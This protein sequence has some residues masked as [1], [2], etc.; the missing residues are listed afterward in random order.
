MIF[1]IKQFLIKLI[2][3]IL[4]EILLKFWGLKNLTKLFKLTKLQ[5]EE[6]R[7]AILQLILVFS[8]RLEN[9]LLPH[10]RQ[11]KRALIWANLV[12]MCQAEDV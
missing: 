1:S 2:E 12:L 11:K 5:L 4:K 3:E 10:Q 7:V 8:Q 6:H 9:C